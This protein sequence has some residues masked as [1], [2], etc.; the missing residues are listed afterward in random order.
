MELEY[1][2]IAMTATV[3]VLGSCVW[4]M[5]Q[6]LRIV[7]SLLSARIDLNADC[8]SIA[9][10]LLIAHHYALGWETS[11]TDDFIWEDTD[12]LLAQT[13]YKLRG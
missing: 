5:H 9:R 7:L 2:L 10:D 11:R 3:I 13:E 6:R 4:R 8:I 12:D 1:Y